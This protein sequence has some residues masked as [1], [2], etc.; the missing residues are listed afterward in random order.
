MEAYKTPDAHLSH[1]L[2]GR[3]IPL[4]I[5]ADYSAEHAATTIRVGMGSTSA[6]KQDEEF[7]E[8]RA[9]MATSQ[10]GERLPSF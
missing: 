1:A 4:L 6:V 2:L 5:A 10:G 7:R 3:A 9:W 8:L